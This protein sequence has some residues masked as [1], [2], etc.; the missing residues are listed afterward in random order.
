MVLYSHHTGIMLYRPLIQIRLYGE[1]AQTGNAGRPLAPDQL[2]FHQ[3]NALAVDEV[4]LYH[5]PL[6]S[7]YPMPS[8]I[9]LSR[10]E[11][12]LY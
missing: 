1:Y 8:S 9:Q 10:Q 6:V 5:K 4:V 3:Y 11:K 2:N 12:E 7:L